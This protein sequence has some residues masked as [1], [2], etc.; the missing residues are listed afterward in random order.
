MLDLLDKFQECMVGIIVGV[1]PW[2]VTA[3]CAIYR[4]SK[5]SEGN[6]MDSEKE[7]PI[8]HPK[9]NT[10]HDTPLLSL[11]YRPH[12]MAM[13][14]PMSSDK[15]FDPSLV[16]GHLVSNTISSDKWSDLWHL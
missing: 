12:Y 7:R 5:V 2:A 14:T 11:P 8:D 16:I 15:W 3:C 6:G 9:L 13:P 4:T 1:S 10:F